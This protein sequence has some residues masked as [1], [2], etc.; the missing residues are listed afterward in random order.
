MTGGDGDQVEEAV[1]VQDLVHRPELGVPQLVAIGQEPFEGAG[2]R[3]H[4]AEVGLGVD[5]VGA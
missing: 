2:L 1:I 4:A 3:I 5:S